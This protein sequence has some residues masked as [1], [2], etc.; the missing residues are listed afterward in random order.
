MRYYT[1][2]S[3]QS[4]K[5]YHWSRAR[6]YNFF[7]WCKIRNN[8]QS[9][10]CYHKATFSERFLNFYSFHHFKHK[11]NIIIIKNLKY[12]AIY[13]SSEI[14]HNK[15]LKVIN[16]FLISNNFFLSTIKILYNNN[17]MHNTHILQAIN[18]NFGQLITS[19]TVYFM[20]TA[21]RQDYSAS[22]PPIIQTI[23]K[24]HLITE[25]LQKI[26]YHTKTHKRM[27]SN[28]VYQIPCTKCPKSYIGQTGK[29]RS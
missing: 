4:T 25:T 26:L 24:L 8:T 17:V 23:L 6:F 5:F 11:I 1:F 14:Y 10:Y 21:P 27:H 29:Y 16:G 22:Y 12:W 20:T 3:F 28:I 7:T 15:I 19:T 2:N 18:H 13:L 9:T